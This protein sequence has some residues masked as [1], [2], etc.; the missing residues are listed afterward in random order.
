M[1]QYVTQNGL[2]YPCHPGDASKHSQF[3]LGFR[4]CFG[5]GS[6][7][8]TFSDCPTKQDKQCYR[9]FHWNLHC[10][11]PN[12]FFRNERNKLDLSQPRQQLQLAS[13]PYGPSYQPQLTHSNTLVPHSQAQQPPQAPGNAIGRGAGATTPAWMA[14]LSSAPI[15][16]DQIPGPPPLPPRPT[17]SDCPYYATQ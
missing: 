14:T 16:S 2:Q 13:S 10:H 9:K 11:K 8:H 15:P 5:C 7:H 3:P 1:Q 6:E 17:D 12:V 4:G